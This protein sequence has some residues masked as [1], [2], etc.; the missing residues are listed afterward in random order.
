M[1][2]KQQ[3]QLRRAEL[4]RIRDESKVLAKCVTKESLGPKINGIQI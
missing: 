1:T 4:K 2:K 3:S